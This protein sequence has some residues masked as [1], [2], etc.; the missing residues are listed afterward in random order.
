VTE[1][2]QSTLVAGVEP[3]AASTRRAAL[4]ALLVA[5][6]AVVGLA[7][8]QGGYF[9][10]SWGLAGTLLLWAIGLWIVVSGR[11][12]AGRLDLVFLGLFAAFTC[13]VGLSISW[14][15]VPAHS[16]LELERTVLVLAGVTAVLALARQT[17]AERLGALLLAAITA[18]SLYS[19]ATRLFPDRLGSY[20]PIAGYRLS[21]PIGY[22]NSLGIFAVMGLL[23]AVGIASDVRGR[24]GRAAAAVALVPLAATV[25][26]TYSRA[27]WIAL[28]IGL[29]VLLAFTSRRL[30]T[31][32]T[33]LVVGLPAVIAVLVA[34]RPHALTHSDATLADSA[35]AGHRV[36]ALVV[37]LAAVAALL[38]LVLDAVE[39]RVEVPRQL[40]VAG[41]AAVVVVLLAVLAGAL[42]REG[43]PLSIS[44]RAWHAFSA[45]PASGPNLNSRLL[46]F[47]GNGRVELWRAA[48]D[49]ASAHP[50][51]GSGA[52][53]FER[54]WQSRKD[55]SFKVRDAHSLYVETFAELGPPG[56]ALLVSALLV[57]VAA[58][59]LVRRRAV[60]PAALGAYAAFL[61]H[62]GVDWDWELSGVTLT[63]VLVASILLIAARGSSAREL[64]L[65]VR[66]AGVA[67]VLIASMGM[68]VAYLGNGA[69]ARAQTAVV[70]K[71]YAS[72]ID[73]AN[74]ARRLMPWSPWPLIA[75]GDAL[76]AANDSKAA[77]ASYRHAIAIDDGEWRAWL[78]LALASQGHARASALARARSLYPRS[79][80]IARAAE[81][82][83]IPT[84]G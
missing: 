77:V 64:G 19:L 44:R 49:L 39:R 82:L 27:S 84:N 2:A 35:H 10:T 5:A 80:E 68:I 21:T 11:T 6:G 71:S 16:V 32:A 1:G 14:S 58:A 70:D 72:A 62:A 59:F 38:A 33:M 37:A 78:G 54:Y 65:T 53:T 9:P 30:R 67:A 43:S 36:A 60:I 42:V 57:P 28:G 52:G 8:A 23:L 50:A 47:S 45:P 48:R 55:A 83:K 12:D 17:D 76:L 7:S 24:W 25:Y 75:R 61:V 22:W 63:A 41:G 3:T 40:R 81:Q 69:L 79:S 34:S 26:Y 56:V 73:D 15:V 29:C 66:V 13:W 46:S 51:L 20:D 31:I 74:R 4:P 18:V